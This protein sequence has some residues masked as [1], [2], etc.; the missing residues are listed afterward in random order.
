MIRLK[1]SKYGDE[2]YFPISVRIMDKENTPSGQHELHSH[3]FSE[4]VFI[5]AG[6]VSHICNEKNQILKSGDFFIIHPG[7]EHGYSEIDDGARCYNILYNSDI[8]IPMLMLTSFAFVHE[9][10]PDYKT[11]NTGFSG[12]LGTVAPRDLARLKCYL[13]DMCT[14]IEQREH[15]HQNLLVS[16]FMAVIIMLSRYYHDEKSLEET[17]S[18][19]KVIGAMKVSCQNRSLTVKDYAKASG[20]CSRT[21][22]RRFKNMFGIGPN[23]YLQ[24][25]R[26]NRAIVLLQDTALSGEAIA[27]QCGFYN[28]GHMWKAFKQHLNV[29][30]SEVRSGRHIS[31]ALSVKEISR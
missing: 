27:T 19:N 8:P 23:E 22:L 7:I 5:A 31:K 2:K 29:T 11:Q 4:L 14:E 3:E 30:P 17:W 25:L 9:V 10:Y 6:T 18:L 28:S 21:L 16:L 1:Y 20:M 24:R 26:I 13:D 12:I 15:G